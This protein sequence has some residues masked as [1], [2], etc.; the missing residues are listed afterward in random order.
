[1]TDVNASD[2]SS[3]TT[4]AMSRFTDENN[5]SFVLNESNIPMEVD[6]DDQIYTSNPSKINGHS[7]PTIEHNEQEKDDVFHSG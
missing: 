2:Y 1:M 4:A 6:F 3:A 7:S 5:S